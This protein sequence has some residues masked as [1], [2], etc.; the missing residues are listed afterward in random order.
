MS[1]IPSDNHLPESDEPEENNPNGI[2]AF[3]LLG[4]FLEE[5]NW[6]AH[7][8]PNKYIY[9]LTFQG[10]SALLHC[11]A[12]VRVN[13]E[14]LLIYVVSPIKVEEQTRLI[15]A[16]YLTRANYGLYIGNFELDFNDGEVRYKSSIDFENV[17]LNFDLIRNT[18][19]P[20]L[21]LMDRY[22]PGLMKVAYGGTEPV[23][24]INEIEG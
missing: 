7:Q 10:K 6:N 11:Y 13:A 16:E 18:M 5:N 12:Q 22:L 15:A 17:E 1:D 19:Y 23:D 14:Q 3:M 20:A 9:R 24:A 8:L 4:Q 21:Q 2:H